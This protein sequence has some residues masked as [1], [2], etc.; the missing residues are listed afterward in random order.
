MKKRKVYL[1]MFVTFVLVSVVFLA[2]FFIPLKKIGL[3]ARTFNKNAAPSYSQMIY[4]GF[5]EDALNKPM[6]VA[7]INQFIYVT[8][9]NNKRVQV[10][11]LAGAPIFKFGKE[12]EGPGQFKFPYG[13][14]GDSQGNIYVSDLYNGCISIHDSKGKFIKYFAEKDPKEKTIEAPGSFRIINNK[15]YVT[16]IKKSKLLIFDL[17]GKIIKEIGEPGT[18][19]GQF[20]APNA[21]TVDKD[22]N[23]YVVDTGNQRIQEFNKDGTF[24]RIINGSLDAKGDSVFVNPRGIAIDSQGIV[25]LVSNLTHFIYGFDKDGKKLFTFGGSGESNTQFSLPNGLFIDKNDTIYITDS[26]NQRVAVYK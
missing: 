16:D 8:D 12:G 22:E 15:V 17:D 21:V 13:I 23:I 2:S 26:A 10:F 24:V 11:D 19:Q 9:T 20:R 14:D 1:S 7:E 6:D 18:K 5:G 25:Y 3:T 4:G